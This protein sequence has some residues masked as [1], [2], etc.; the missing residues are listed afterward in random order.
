M[1]KISKKHTSKPHG[2]IISSREF[3]VALKIFLLAALVRAVYLYDSSDNPT[4]SAPIVDSLTYDQ[5]AAGL[6][7]TGSLTQEFFWQP[8]FYPLFL[9]LIYKLTN[10]SILAV[11]IVQALLGSLTSVLAYFL[12]KKLFDKSVGVLSGVFVALYMPLVFYDGELLAAGWSAF[13][14]LTLMLA[15]IKT[16]EK[17]TLR[18]CFALG[19]F[20]ALSI[21]TRPEFLPFSAAAF[22]WLLLVWIRR[23]TNPKKIVPCLS[24]LL[25]GFF[26]IAAPVAFLSY[27]TVGKASFLPFSGGI[28]LYIGN[29]PDYKE[30]IN[31]RPGLAWEKLT[32]LPAEHGAKNRFE[33]E[34]FFSDKLL[35]YIRTQPAG[36]LKGL[37]YKSA[38]FL[39]SRETPRNFDIY[40]FRKWSPLLNIGLWKSG[41]FGF[42]FGVL[43][44]LAVIGLIF[45]WRK[46]P[47]PVWLFLILYP[48]SV[49]LV[50]V[51]SRYRTP[52]IPL[53]AVLAAAG[54]AAIWRLFQ[55]RNWTKLTAALAIVLTVAISTSL[56]GPFYAEQLDYE[57]ELY[58]G[59]ADSL[60]KHGHTAEAVDAYSRAVTLRND[61]VE[62]HQNLAILL[63]KAGS[64]N[65]AVEHYRTALKFDPNNASLYEGLGEALFKQGKSNDAI[66][67]YRKAIEIAPDS[68]TAYD[69]LG[70]AFFFLKRIPE[71]MQYYLKSIELDPNDSASQNNIG[72]AFV[73]QGQLSQAVEHYEISLSLK[74]DAETLNNLANALAGLG[75]FQ[76]AVISYNKA[77]RISPN[78]AGIY[79]NLAVCF[80]KQG[81]TDDAVTTY[82]K[83]LSLDPQNIHAKQALERL[84]T[85]KL[86]NP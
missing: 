58:Y 79:C 2:K 44:P 20:A 68:A 19:L 43:L 84:S 62:A 15:L 9:A 60:D 78:D 61:Y 31:I 17:P 56:A 52:A 82:R 4:F 73:M 46:V 7:K 16:A 18:S 49:I 11:K 30:T 85:P 86:S 1:S 50:F 80:E 69:K 51:T 65:D 53:I 37:F 39:S 55:F 72:N 70:T 75:K 76:E 12:G 48:A 35:N 63:V 24:L 81:K 40:L 32:K 41:K 38:Q 8:P 21:I 33:D 26:T 74:E 64:L 45:N 29:N 27:R 23:R 28:N 67:L 83:V 25:A 14:V 6:T 71:A 3:K 54:C 66:E 47:A 22:I 42:P 13:W 5:M 77:L 36:F 10:S 57:P 34:K 59:L